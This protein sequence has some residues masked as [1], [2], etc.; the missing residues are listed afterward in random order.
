MTTA[1]KLWD[2][3]CLRSGLG[4]ESTVKIKGDQLRRIIELSWAEGYRVGESR[5]DPIIDAFDAMF[6]GGRR[7]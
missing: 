7:P 5:R 6:G 2:D 4:D 1:Q 3:L